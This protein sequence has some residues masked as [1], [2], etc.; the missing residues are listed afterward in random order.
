MDQ[1]ALTCDMF[2]FRSIFVVPVFN[3]NDQF[4]ESGFTP[5]TSGGIDKFSSNH[6]GHHLRMRRIGVIDEDQVRPAAGI[7][8]S[9]IIETGDPG[10]ICR[11]QIPDQEEVAGGGRRQP[12][13]RMTASAA[14][15]APLWLPPQL[16]AL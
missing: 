9:A 14:S 8:R 1:P 10:R 5:E 15:I 12:E 11:D 6:G 7:E 13:G 4:A 2:L 16:K 3:G